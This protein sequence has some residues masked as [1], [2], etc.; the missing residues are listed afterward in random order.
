[1]NYNPD[2]VF[3]RILEGQIPCDKVYED[4]HVLAFNDI[5]PKAKIHVLVIPKKPYVSCSD[6][7]SHATEEEI[8]GYYRGV[9][10]VIKKL[11]LEPAGFRLLSNC[12]AQGGQEVFHFHTHIFAGQYLGPM[13]CPHDYA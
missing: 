3:A 2:N 5:S 1:M 6:F 13:I 4:S 8:A 12:G 10:E 9:Q 7:H 11:N